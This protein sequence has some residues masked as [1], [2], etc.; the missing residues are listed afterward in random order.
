MNFSPPPLLPHHLVLHLFKYLFST[1]NAIIYYFY[2]TLFI[3]IFFCF[4]EFEN[5][6]I[7]WLC[8]LWKQHITQSRLRHLFKK[9]QK[10]WT[11]SGMISFIHQKITTKR[12]LL[13]KKRRSWNHTNEFANISVKSENRIGENHSRVSRLPPWTMKLFFFF[14][15]YN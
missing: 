3:V 7:P 14:F 11:T 6:Q 10:I 12:I 2:V 5:L 8:F 9:K 4:S 15:N 1:Q 13:Q